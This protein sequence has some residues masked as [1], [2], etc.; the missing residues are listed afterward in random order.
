MPDI[1]D[2]RNAPPDS[3]ENE[4][5]V[6]AAERLANIK[7]NMKSHSDRLLESI[8]PRL[9]F[10]PRID[11][12]AI[13]FETTSERNSSDAFIKSLEDA[14][15]A[16]KE[17]LDKDM[18]LELYACLQSGHFI[19]VKDVAAAGQNGITM[20][21]L[22]GDEECLVLMN[23]NNFQFIYI[24]TKIT[25]KSPERKIGFIYSDDSIK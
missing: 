4:N 25:E 15:K 23:Q 16:W 8:R 1:N 5:T 12:D 21:G 14:Y 17:Q 3:E 7:A 20:T 18:K 13:N 19:S 22:F 2:L 9:D 6:S 11:L 10:N 24:A